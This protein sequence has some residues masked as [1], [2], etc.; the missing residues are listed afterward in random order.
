MFYKLATFREQEIGYVA[1]WTGTTALGNGVILDNGTVAGVNATSSLFSFNIQGA[2][3]VSPVN[4][5]S[6]TGVSF[7]SISQA[8]NVGIGTTT[9][10]AT[11]HIIANAAASKGLIIQATSSQTANILELQNSA[12][13]PIGT[14]SND[15][16]TWNLS[17]NT[18]DG[19][20]LTLR[21]LVTV[22]GGGAVTVTNNGGAGYVIKQVNSY[23]G[24]NTGV[25]GTNERLRID[26]NGN[27]GVNTSSPLAALQV[28]N[29][30]INEAGTTTNITRGLYISP[31][32]TNAANVLQG[33][34]YRGFETS[35]Y[36]LVLA[37][38]T[39]ISQV[40]GT[41]HNQIT[42]NTTTVATLANAS[43]VYINGAPK[44]TSNLT[45][46]SS[47]ALT[48]FGGT[49]STTTNA[50]G[51]WLQAPTGATNNYAAIFNGG[52]IG[53]GTSTPISLFDVAGTAQLRGS[54]STVGLVVTSGGNVG[55]GTANPGNARAK[56]NK[57]H[58]YFRIF[59]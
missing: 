58:T 47:T 51:L 16:K 41:L 42:V 35:G 28:T 37:S 12:G 52:N 57:G 22:D 30:T 3:G 59:S 23:I 9:P 11:M 31:N 54:S 27:I 32:P 48:V 55:I 36:T 10:L 53:V 25:S 17:G 19:I 50:Y 7:F 38:T 43:N 45:I 39:A 24:F 44:S 5:S 14:I 29:A 8:G 15:G 26:N 56:G 21:N 49:V 13:Q 33:T 34:D 4:I 20:T 40:Y 2:S 6:S 1:R 46:A 18:N